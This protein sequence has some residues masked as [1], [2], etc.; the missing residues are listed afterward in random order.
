MFAGVEHVGIG[1]ADMDAALEFFAD[2]LGFSEVLFDWTG[3]LPGLEEL[4]HRRRTRARVA[5]LASRFA[6]PLGPGKIRL[7]QTLEAGGTPP[8]PAGMG[9]GEL[10]ISEV[11]V[12]ARDVAPSTSSSSTRW[13]ARR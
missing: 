6:T 2:R 11:C 12:H 10:G 7:V 4:T 3:E 5:M 9:W 1:V 13:A 8:L